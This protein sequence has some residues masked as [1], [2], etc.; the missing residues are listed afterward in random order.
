MLPPGSA[1]TGKRVNGP[2]AEALAKAGRGRRACTLQV[3]FTAKDLTRS[4]A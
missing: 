2:P 4:A 1:S 3:E